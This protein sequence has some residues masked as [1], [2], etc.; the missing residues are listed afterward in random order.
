MHPAIQ[1]AHQ[2]CSAHRRDSP[3][4]RRDSPKK[5]AV[6][7]PNGYIPQNCPVDSKEMPIFRLFT[8]RRGREGQ[9]TVLVKTEFLDVA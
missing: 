9:K 5:V 1:E 2:P 7:T 4:H 3:N 8:V 6:R